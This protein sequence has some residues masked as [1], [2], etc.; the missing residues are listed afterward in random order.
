MKLESTIKG[1]VWE[2]S[3]PDGSVAIHYRRFGP[4]ARM[5]SI[6]VGSGFLL[7]A[8]GSFADWMRPY[9]SEGGALFAALIFGAIGGSLLNTGLR[10][11]T[12]R[13]SVKSS[14]WLAVDR[15]RIPM[16]EVTFVGTVGPGGRSRLY[17]DTKGRRVW[18]TPYLPD[19]AINEAHRLFTLHSGVG[20]KDR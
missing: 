18:L 2:E 13:F 5:V 6:V 17:V 16:M 14:E 20:W 12:G 3:S 9:G 10:K 15:D 1:E 7:V 8:L 19:A 11:A 4:V